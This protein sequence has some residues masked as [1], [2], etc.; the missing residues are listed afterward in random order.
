MIRRSAM[1]LLLLGVVTGP[2]TSSGSDLR[3]KDVVLLSAA[4]V[5]AA[6]S[7]YGAFGSHYVSSLSLANPHPFPMTVTAYILPAGADNTDYRASAKTIDLP[8]SGGTRIEDPLATIWGASGLATIY[9]ETTPSSGNDG[10]FAVDSRV[11]NVAN[12]AATFGLALPGTLSG[13]TAGDVG[14]AADVESDAA[15]RTNFGLFNDSA[16]T[17][18][19]TVEL[20]AN[21]GHLLGSKA[22]TLTPYSLI[23]KNV[24]DVTPSGFGRATLRVTPASGYAGQIIG[25]T[26]VVDNATGDGA[27][28]LLQVY[29]LL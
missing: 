27:S 20:L 26:A 5:P 6:A 12:P 29:R 11:L 25:Y 10:A 8:A 23:Q 13:V 28:A 4:V 7:L 3:R 9:L 19:V 15:Y 22:Y 2:A 24:T 16:E 17:T 14:Y 18:V 21:D 1:A